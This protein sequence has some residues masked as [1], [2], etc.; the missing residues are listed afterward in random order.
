M[1]PIAL[2]LQ[3]LFM[4]QEDYLYKRLPPVANHLIVALYLGIC[5]YSF[6]YFYVRLRAHRDLRAGLLHAAAI[7]SSGC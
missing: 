3:I 2:T 4:Y 5:V 7:S 1:L 6:V